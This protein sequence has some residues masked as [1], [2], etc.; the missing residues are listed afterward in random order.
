MA[1]SDAG[2]KKM[3]MLKSSD[4]EEFEVEE[5]VA[6]E[7]QTIRHMI[8]DDCAE[9]SIPI[10][11]INSEILS[12]VIEYYNKHVL[13]KPGNV[14]TG[15]LGAATSNTVAPTALAE[16]LKIWDAEFIKVNHA[17][18][19]DLIQVLY[20]LI[21]P[22]SFSRSTFSWCSPS[23]TRIYIVLARLANIYIRFD[24]LPVQP[25]R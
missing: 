25:S 7:S 12:K 21:R 10:P 11:N 2:E 4:G 1:T 13:A 8:E 20:P 18:L 9:K 3:I 14:A 19:F 5:V 6:M 15:S 22:F 17:T 23:G 24:G 16:D